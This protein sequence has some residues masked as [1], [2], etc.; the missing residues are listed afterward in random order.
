MEKITKNK[1]DVVL[2]SSSP[3]R[4]EMLE[5][6]GWAFKVIKPDYDEQQNDKSNP[7][8]YVLKNAE[9]KSLWVKNNLNFTQPTVLIAAD[10]IV[11]LDSK[12]LEKPKD[13]EDA[14]CMLRSL[15]EKTHQVITGLSVIYTDGFDEKLKT[16]AVSTD[17]SFRQLDDDSIHRYI[18]SGEPMDKAGSYGFQGKGQFLTDRIDGSATN[19]IGMPLKELVDVMDELIV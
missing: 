17:V 1:I 8:S 11:V 18:S 5:S 10:T 6:M 14:F 2:A 19:V 9:G 13:K 4:K 7:E 16:I 12:V 15:S 3:R